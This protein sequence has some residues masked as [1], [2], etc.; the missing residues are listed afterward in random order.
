MTTLIELI[1]AYGRACFNDMA[2]E[3]T[4]RAALV[5]GIEALQDRIE[6]NNALC[7]KRVAEVTRER[8]A[9]RAELD[10]LKG[11]EPVAWI[12]QAGGVKFL[13]T[14]WEIAKREGYDTPLYAGAAPQAPEPVNCDKCVY[15]YKDADQKPCNTCIHSGDFVSNFEP[16]FTGEAQG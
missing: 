9:L 7:I 15:H 16:R 1:D 12:K 14:N 3:A 8:D 2:N 11:S 5:Q 4:V 13:T 10:A 6:S